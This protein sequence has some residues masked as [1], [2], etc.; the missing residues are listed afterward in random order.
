MKGEINSTTIIGIFSPIISKHEER[1]A[2]I[3]YD[4][5][6]VDV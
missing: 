4:A 3:V 5:L 2:E 1:V 6:G